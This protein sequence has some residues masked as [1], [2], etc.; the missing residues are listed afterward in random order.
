MEDLGNKLVEEHSMVSEMAFT[1]FNE[2][3]ELIS[4]DRALTNDSI[5]E[6]FSLQRVKSSALDVADNLIREITK[7]IKIIFNNTKFNDQLKIESSKILLRIIQIYNHVLINNEA[8]TF[9]LVGFIL[10]ELKKTSIIENKF[11]LLSC[12][13]ELISRDHP[14][15]S[16]ERVQDFV[17]DQL[18]R[19]NNIKIQSICVGTL[20]RLNE[21]FAG[22][23]DA[24]HKYYGRLVN[25]LKN[26]IKEFD[27]DKLIK[28]AILKCVGSVFAG[29]PLSEPDTVYFL[30]MLSAKL[31]IEVE[32]LFIVETISRLNQAGQ[33]SAE[34]AKILE[35]LT[36]QIA[37]NLGSNNYDLNVK[38]IETISKIL[39]IIG[40]K[41]S[42]KSLQELLE[43]SKHLLNDGKIPS[44]FRAIVDTNP[45][46][47]KPY[48]ELIVRS[49]EP[50]YIS[51]LIASGVTDTPTVVKIFKGLDLVE[52]AK[53]IS[54]TLGSI[55]LKA[56]QIIN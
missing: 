10:E 42:E 12:L 25:F 40:N 49:T 53:K 54:L 43:K 9:T 19:V 33:C 4:I 16:Y 52:K 34:K 8:E 22:Q 23:I 35:Q 14:F 51:K 27:S 3:I 55:N 31:K 45:K 46:L 7:R 38:S 41:Y 30:E 18:N 39:A 44:F 47:L 56:A 48:S 32:K 15:N 13:R 24:N 26:K 29:L 37:E 2:L 5:E 28:L 50:Y 1:T 17:F 6:E 21:T 11:N 36:K 20:R